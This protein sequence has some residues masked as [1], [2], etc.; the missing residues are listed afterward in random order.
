MG[1]IK[2]TVGGLQSADGVQFTA[3][4][5]SRQ[6]LDSGAQLRWKRSN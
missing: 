1:A 3:I 5:Q 6:V 2:L 4:D